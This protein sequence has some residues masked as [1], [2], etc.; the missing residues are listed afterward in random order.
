MRDTQREAETQAEGEAGSMWGARCGTRSQDPGI[1]SWAEGRRSTAEPPRRPNPRTISNII[2]FNAPIA[3][4]RKEVTFQ[5][6]FQVS[7]GRARMSTHA[8]FWN[9]S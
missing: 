8:G 1:T 3:Q 9:V 7:T 4:I 6:T 5:V 2:L